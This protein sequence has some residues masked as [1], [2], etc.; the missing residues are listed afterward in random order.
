M[1]SDGRYALY[2]LKITLKMMCTHAKCL[3]TGSHFYTLLKN[4][5]LIYKKLD[6]LRFKFLAKL[7]LNFC[8]RVFVSLCVYNKCVRVHVYI[9]IQGGKTP[10]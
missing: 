9:N 10:W 4:N 6:N 2:M 1:Y 5:I 3:Y 7:M 8:F